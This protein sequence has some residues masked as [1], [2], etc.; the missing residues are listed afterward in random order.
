MKMHSPRGEDALNDK[1][2][3]ECGANASIL[4]KWISY[5]PMRWLNI[6]LG[7]NLENIVKMIKLA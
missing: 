7:D 2:H 5:K 1:G 4:Q 3:R 6:L